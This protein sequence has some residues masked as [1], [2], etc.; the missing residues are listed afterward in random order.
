MPQRLPI[1]PQRDRQQVLAIHHSRFGAFMKNLPPQSNAVARYSVRVPSFFTKG[2]I[3][4][5]DLV[6][7]ATSSLGYKACTGCEQ[8]AAALNRWVVFSSDRKK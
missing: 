7:R 1:E 6:K 8:R 3:G 2:D 5:G 4:L